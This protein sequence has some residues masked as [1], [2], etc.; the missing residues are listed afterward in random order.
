[1]RPKTERQVILGFDLSSTKVAV[2]GANLLPKQTELSYD[3]TYWRK[4]V[5]ADKHSPLVLKVARRAVNRW[6]QI[7]V[8]QRAELHAFIEAPVVA[9]VRNIQTTIKQSF[10]NGV[11]QEVLVANG[12][13]TTLLAPTQWKSRAGVKGNA[14]KATVC[15]WLQESNRW[16]YEEL[17]EDQDLID[18]AAVATVG[19]AMVA[20]R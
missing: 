14:D 9:G 18:A 1:M 15:E 19:A 5:F 17:G 8:R 13:N 10:V 16:L 11:I 12:F 2:V 3:C 20:E 4:W 6:V 7:H